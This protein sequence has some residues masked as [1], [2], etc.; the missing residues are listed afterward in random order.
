M[1]HFKLSGKAFYFS[2]FFLILVGFGTLLHFMGYTFQAVDQ[3]YCRNLLPWSTMH[4]VTSCEHQRSGDD[5]FESDFIVNE[6]KYLRDNPYQQTYSERIMNGYPIADAYTA[7]QYSLVVF[8]TKFISSVS[9]VNFSALAI[10]FLSF[11]VAYRIA[12][13]LKISA[14][15]SVL[16]GVLS[17]P[18]AYVASAETWNCAL[19]SYGFFI[20]GLLELYQL[21]RKVLGPFLI[22]TGSF[23]L[24]L[25]S[26]YQIIL[27]ALI[28]FILLGL[29]Y[30]EVSD[31]KKF[32]FCWGSLIAI[33]VGTVCVLNFFLS[34]HYAF[35]NTSNKVFHQVNFSE[36]LTSKNFVL[37]PIG[38]LGAEIGTFHRRIIA[39]IFGEHVASLMV[40]LSSPGPIFLVFLGIGSGLLYKKNKIFFVIL[41]FWFLYTVGI[42]EYFLSL[43]VGNPFRDETSIRSGNLFFLFSVWPAVYAFTLFL[44]QAKRPNQC[45]MRLIIIAVSYVIFITSITIAYVFIKSDTWYVESSFILLSCIL[46]FLGLLLER[47]ST[48]KCPTILIRILFISSFLLPIV[49]RLFL[50]V[51]PGTLTIE[52]QALYYPPTA[53][54]NILEKNNHLKRTLLIVTPGEAQLFTGDGK[55]VVHANLPMLLGL[56]GVTGYRNPLLKDYME[57][58]EYHRLT[59]ENTGSGLSAQEQM[60]GFKKSVAYLS[61]NILPLQASRNKINLSHATKNYFLLHG[62]DSIIG[63]HDLEIIDSDWV[64]I[65]R[66]NDLSFWKDTKKP[67]EFIFS[68]SVKYIK[69]RMEQLNYMFDGELW[70]PEKEIIVGDSYLASVTPT[71]NDMPEVKV[72][73]QRDGYRLIRYKKNN[74]PGILTLPVTYGTR[75]V[76]KDPMN[77][78]LLKT[79]KVNYTFLGVLIPKGSGEIELIY[80]DQAS[81]FHHMISLLG[82][83]IFLLVFLLL[84]KYYVPVA[85]NKRTK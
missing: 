28:N 37:D 20:L 27:Y 83:G 46:F 4:S 17:I 84:Y 48:I 53:F 30:F 79:F 66:E 54:Q 72:I 7:N 82:I 38:F 81:K 75:W 56:R 73:Q 35:L 9:S 25:S 24:L 3:I 62:I 6:L 2:S 1:I 23:L 63:S 78:K 47:M 15:G 61:N 18:L 21:N 80:N 14:L 39:F 68:R 32:L 58:S 40:G 41:L 67:P 71:Q 44:N 19:L 12:E 16:F 34:N 26:A 77:H 70:H 22:M 43:T 59:F 55:P 8:L 85:R 60:K 64:M 31:R 45:I 36:I 57:L 76:A 50:G 10:L 33:F 52:P 69:G 42:L 13:L 5:L 51:F 11:L 74:A 49:A 65:G 29:F